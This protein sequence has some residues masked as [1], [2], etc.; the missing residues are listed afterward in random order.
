MSEDAENEFYHTGAVCRFAPSPSGRL[1]LGNMRTAIVNALAARRFGGV[2]Q[3]RIED[4]D[5]A[6]ADD[7]RTAEIAAD[8]EWMGIEWA[9]ERPG[10]PYRQSARAG[11]HS[12]ALTALRRRGRAYPCFC[13]PAELERARRMA[14][15]AG[16]PPRYSGKCGRLSES[17]AARRVAAGEAHAIR[18]RMPEAGEIVFDDLARGATRFAAAEL[19]DFVARRTNGDF[20]FFFVNAVDDSELG[21]TVVLRGDD[22]LAN[23]PRQL[24]LLEALEARAPRYGHLS[25]MTDADGGPLSKRR[26]AVGIGELRE[27]GFLPSALWNYLA[28][29]AGV[30]RERGAFLAAA[31]LAAA[32]DFGGLSRSPTRHDEGQLRH[33]QKLAALD[34]SAAECAEWLAAAGVEAALAGVIR[35]NVVLPEDAA[36]WREILTGES[37]AP[38]AAAT[39]VIRAAGG[40]FF[41]TAAGLVSADGG[42]EGWKGFCGRVSR[43]TGRKG[44]DLYRPLRAVLTGRVDGPEMGGM[45]EALGAGKAKGRL[46][47]AAER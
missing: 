25:L 22:H 41:R 32:F 23:T 44:R 43:A 9:G 29:T 26:G 20:S 4:T 46:E 6:R 33:W 12:A 40:D 19:G 15:A 24:A 36:V 16:R 5:R 42:T 34:L 2:L 17:E 18:F 35:E 1:H 13:A 10:V 3:L 39:E 47:K 27:R 38:D 7:S 37:P 30:C 8:L 14:V 11:A 21:V 31:E 28:R 45:F